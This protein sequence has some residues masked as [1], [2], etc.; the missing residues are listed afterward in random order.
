MDNYEIVKEIG[1]GTFGKVYLVKSKQSKKQYVWKKIFFGN[2]QEKERNQLKNEVNILSELKNDYIV[3]YYDK[4]ID[5]QGK[6][7]TIVMEYCPGGD[8]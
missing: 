3:K 6:V 1:E 2:M 5:K 8:L 7:L 4:F